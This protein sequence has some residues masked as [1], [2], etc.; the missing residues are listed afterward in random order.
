MRN[1]LLGLFFLGLIATQAKLNA[2]QYNFRGYSLEEGLPQSQVY[3]IV[4][5]SRGSLWQATQGGGI[6]RFNGEKFDVF[7]IR[8][9]LVDNQAN[10]LFED[11]K[12]NLWIATYRGISKFDGVKFT[13]YGEKEGF[14]NVNFA[15]IYE[16]AKGTIWVYTQE[17]FKNAK[18]FYL[19]NGKFV[20]FKKETPQLDEQEIFTFYQTKD[21]NFLISTRQDLWRFDGKRL[22]ALPFNNAEFL[23][24]NTIHQITEDKE[25]NLFFASNMQETFLRKYVNG[26][27]SDV[28]LPESFKKAA[29]AQLYTDSKN[30]IWAATTGAGVLKYDG[31]SV[32]PFS[33]KNGLAVN[34]IFCI[35]ED[36]EGNI[37]IGTDGEGL[38]RYT[39]D[40]FIYLNAQDGLVSENIRPIYESSDGSIW[41]GMVGAGV[42][43]LDSTGVST[44]MTDIG[45]T[46]G[47]IRGIIEV[48]K[49]RML[50]SSD[51]G[52]YYLVG[53]SKR[54]ANKDFGLPENQR[55]TN[56]VKIGDELW[57][58]LHN[59]K[60]I[61]YNTVTKET[62]E[63]T[64]R[65]GLIDAGIHYI[66]KDSKN[67]IWICSNSG[68]TKYDRASKS[69]INYTTKDGL[70]DKWMLHMAEDKK[71]R[72]WFA[73][74]GGGVVCYDGQKFKTITT[75]D[76]IG[77]DI[78][79]SIQV[80][81]NGYVWLGTQNGVERLSFDDQGK[82]KELKSYGKVEGFVGI[83]NNG[84]AGYKDSQGNL[85]FG[86]IKGL[87]KYN[88]KADVSN[89]TPPKINVTNL[90]LFFKPVNWVS[91]EYKD[92]HQGTSSWFSLP[93][94][95]KLPHN[96][97]HVSF[98]F[99]ALSFGA[100]EKVLY[101]WKLEGADEVWSPAIRKP[102]AIYANLSPGKYTL[103]VRAAN[104]D[105]VWTKEP[106]KYSFEIKTPFWEM[107]WFRITVLLVLA[108]IIII[109]VRI[110][111]K[112]I[113][114]QKEKLQFM[115]DKKTQE[116][117]K[118]N[119][120]ILEK[121][122]LLKT[123]KDELLVQTEE[124][125]QQQEENIAQREFIE[126][127]NV[128]LNRQNEQILSSIHSAQT[129]QQAI[130]PFPERLEKVLGDY[131]IL[132]K[133]KDIVSGDFYWLY[134]IDGLTFISVIDCTGHGVQGAF[135]SM[136][137]Y[138]LL[139]EIIIDKKIHEPSKILERLHKLTRVALKQ[140]RTNNREGMEMVMCRLEKVE[141]EKTKVTFAGA[142]RPFHYVQN[143]RFWELKGDRES[144]GGGRHEPEVKTF[145]D[146]TVTLPKGTKC[147]LSSDGL[148]DNPTPRRTKFGRNHFIAFLVENAY[149]SMEAQKQAWE[150]EIAFSQR[151]AEQR[152]DITVMG[153]KV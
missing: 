34:R 123:Q 53:K 33:T 112:G 35:Y 77:T 76:G 6:S 142:K 97:N 79:Y 102:E 55:T 140:D 119:E 115:V 12:K 80:D 51:A 59:V 117:R 26:N 121:S 20:N 16:D 66:G 128:E 38:V 133:P 3:A 92:Y 108:A 89:D 75:K 14:S 131:F 62:K 106:L 126:Q 127:K 145:T 130:L 11:S 146:Q 149:M 129:I 18:I 150:E 57:F 22:T 15:R 46:L 8:E 94:I 85:W 95:L 116:V 81:N 65:Q 141:D 138:S 32:Q 134:H 151:D 47:S 41:F 82:V 37:W 49:G 152:D 113:E 111:I 5:D 125:R 107:W 23:Q 60:L 143:G 48:S 99:E 27:V 44:Y 148:I 83:E 42:A 90:R 58:A 91:E 2:Q 105:G 101:R 144:I 132:Y 39:G 68:I 31:K 45:T 52:L 21:K 139:N 71:G 98:D 86:T 118:Q 24:N 13:N 64:K 29:V 153:F 67:N 103:K 25:G 114:A 54:H 84:Q 43:K 137:G 87:I 72:L 10:Y 122:R 17:G 61:C 93:Q 88:P 4:Q 135:M 28:A 124:L 40:R 56:V 19:K 78:I 30:N 9:G 70:P 104:S 50:F 110:R 147:Y 36:T 74:F 120:E 109:A 100:P 1:I 69:L 7:T 136:I 96:V 63:F 73:T